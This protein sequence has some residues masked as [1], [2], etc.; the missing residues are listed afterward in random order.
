[1]FERYTEKARHTIFFAPC[2][3]SRYGSPCIETQH[4]LLGLLRED[5]AL[6]RDF[7]V[8]P[9][10]NQKFEPKLRGASPH[11]SAFLPRWRYH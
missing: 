8:K 10:S 6:M 4:V 3:A 2:E 11:T 7:S 9:I 5:R 1:M